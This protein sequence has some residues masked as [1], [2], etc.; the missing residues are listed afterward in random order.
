MIYTKEI[1]KQQQQNY[2]EFIMCHHGTI[3]NLKGLPYTRDFSNVYICGQ[4]IDQDLHI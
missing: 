4:V 2:V 3:I 1:T